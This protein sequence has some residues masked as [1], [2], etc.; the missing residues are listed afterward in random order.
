MQG[1]W[2]TVT[3]F[4]RYKGMP[5]KNLKGAD[6]I[7]TKGWTK[8][9]MA[10]QA[11][12]AKNAAGNLVATKTDELIQI[13]E[14]QAQLARMMQLKGAE[15]I[16][17]MKPEDIE[18]ARK[19]LLTGLQEERAALGM[20]EKGGAQSLTQ[21]NVNLPKT[22]FDEILEGQDYASILRLIADVRRER[23]RR[24]GGGSSIESETKV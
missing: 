8:E 22:R 18:Q 14:R 13:R 1:P 7:H 15:A 6:N 16:R 24:I 4:R 23:T 3:E 12:A 9:K 20:N 5:H 19:L 10:I 11:E 2:V 17:D 21:V